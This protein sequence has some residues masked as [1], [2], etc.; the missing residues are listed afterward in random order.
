MKYL[1][2]EIATMMD[3]QLEMKS[4]EK[5][6]VLLLDSRQI[7]NPSESVFF[8]LKGSRHD[9]HLFIDELYDKGVR[10]F[11]VMHKYIVSEKCST[12]NFYFVDDVQ[13]ALQKLVSKHRSKFNIPV[14]A[15]TG[16]N[17]KTIVKEWI[18]QVLGEKEV[19]TRSP[20][21]YNSQVGVPLSVWQI[22]NN[23]T[24]AVFEAGISQKGE[25][26]RLETIIQPDCGMITNIG[27]AHQQNFSTIEEKLIEKL[28]LFKNTKTIFYCKD[29]KLIDKKINEL[30]SNKRLITW[31]KDD[32]ADMR[33]ISIEHKNKTIIKT[34]W[35]KK[36]YKWSLPFDDSISIENA[37]HVLLFLLYNGFD[38]EFIQQKIIQLQPV[39]MRMEQKEGM[40]GALIIN[41]TYSSDLTSL[42]LAIDFLEQQS[43][44]KGMKRTIILSDMFQSGISDSNLYAKVA[45]MIKIS[46][47]DK[48]IGV[49]EII[50]SYASLFDKNAIFF[51][52]TDE[53]LSDLHNFSFTKETILI[54]G[55]RSFEFERIVSLL[56]TKQH[57]TILEINLN[58]LINNLNIFRSKLNINTKVL[59]MVKAFGYGS[60]SFEIA[61]VLQHHKVDYLGVAF[62]DEGMELRQAG[63]SMPIIVMNPEENSFDIMLK[64]NLEPEIYCLRILQSFCNVVENEG[65]SNIPIHIKI[66]TGM[67]RLG[68]RF[69]EIEILITEL[70]KMPNLIVKSVFSHLAASDTAELDDFTRLQIARFEN[71]CE[72]LQIGIGYKFLK[73]I[74]NSAGIERFSYAHF[75]MVRLGI[76]LYGISTEKDT[77]LENAITLKTYISQI[78]TIKS[79]ESVGYGCAQ[80]FENGGVIAVI[81]IGYADGLNRHLSCGVGKVMINRKL[82]PIVGNICMD[83]CML[84]I[85]NIENVKEGDEVTIFGDDYSV[86]ELAKQLNTIPYEILTGIG[87]RVKRIYFKE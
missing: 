25:M 50:S 65:L 1:P 56:E 68:F 31:G 34:I 27:A 3:A 76:G 70:K 36:E 79:G 2:H 77:W 33:I 81:P 14:L 9:G 15:I 67:N 43:R 45:K 54:K 47:I 49:G 18:W 11:V 85:S 12:A 71:A 23:T 69:D 6:S 30:Y 58:A 59:A 44:K 4:T 53:L 52:T 29:H 46:D 57:N 28:L 17:G 39:A 73:H 72:R 83:M 24:L 21:S 19:I 64:Q 32:K 5:P 80:H 82:V 22:N 16:S 84:D 13:S 8:A 42:E 62:A 87:R 55:A 75:D 48:L 66:D 20:R 38:T 7:F 35:N 63:I 40:G 74:L 37:F 51:N 60:G 26:H 41:D 78:K 86:S 61:S 10:N